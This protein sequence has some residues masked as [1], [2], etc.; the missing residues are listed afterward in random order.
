MTGP[1]QE[2]WLLR[3]LDSSGARW[4]VTAQQMMMAQLNQEP[5]SGRAFNLEAWDGYV[6]QRKRLLGYLYPTIT[7][8]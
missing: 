2:R 3:K 5:D 8:T 4:N 1:D 6:A 7:S